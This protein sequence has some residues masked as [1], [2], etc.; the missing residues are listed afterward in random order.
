MRLENKYQTSAAGV[1][2]YQVSVDARDYHR[3]TL[4]ENKYMISIAAV[5]LSSIYFLVVPGR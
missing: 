4:T 3:L 2:V 5:I 1:T